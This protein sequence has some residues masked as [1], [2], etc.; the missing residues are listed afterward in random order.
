MIKRYH[1]APLCIF[2]EVQKITDGDYALVHLFEKNEAYLN[3]FKKAVADGRDVILDNSIFELGEAFDGETFAYWVRQL[4]PTWYI[5]PDCWKDGAKTVE[6]FND[7]VEKYPILPGKR[8]GVAQGKTIEEVIEC[9][10][11]IKDR[12]D[13]I[14]FNLD[15]SSIFYNSFLPNCTLEYK[16]SLVPYC[17]AMSIG[18]HSVLCSL[19]L[20]GVIDETKSHHLLGCGVPQEVQWYDKNWTWIRS[21]DTCNPVMAGMHGR[22]YDPVSGISWKSDAKMCDQMNCF[23]NWRDRS[24]IIENI[25][26]MKDW[27]TLWK[28]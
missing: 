4:K 17:V 26:I 14:A 22:H 12:C 25:N 5:V 21:I 9:Y 8:V 15:F 10:Q 16:A 20:L 23:V 18:R 11:Q 1:E 28:E 24:Y 3:K 19:Q 27:C 13:M 2:D 7:F 6:M